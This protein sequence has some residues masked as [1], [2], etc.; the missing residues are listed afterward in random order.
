MLLL[1]LLAG[2]LLI[3]GKLGCIPRSNGMINSFPTTDLVVR[4]FWRNPAVVRRSPGKEREREET[5]SPAELQKNQITSTVD[6]VGLQG[7]PSS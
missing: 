5:F 7:G 4:Q 2:E 3:L 1:V 6:D